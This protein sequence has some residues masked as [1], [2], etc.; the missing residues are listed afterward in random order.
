MDNKMI[1]SEQGDLEPIAPEPETPAIGL[2]SLDMEEITGEDGENEEM[3]DKDYQ[4][5]LT[6]KQAEDEEGSEQNLDPSFTFILTPKEAEGEGEEG[7][8]EAIEDTGENIESSQAPQS[9]V[10]AA[11]MP[12]GL[13]ESVW[14][15]LE[16]ITEQDAPISAAKGRGTAGRSRGKFRRNPV[17]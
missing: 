7:D 11:G 9:S 5:L 10:P 14:H 2:D 13:P 3:G 8:L 1:L 6:V 17:R 16:P 4:Y 15:D 12:T